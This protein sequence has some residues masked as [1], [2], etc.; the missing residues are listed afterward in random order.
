MHEA[1]TSRSPSDYVS[2][3]EI[4]QRLKI[5]TRKTAELTTA[6]FWPAAIELAPRILRWSWSEIERALAERAPRRTERREPEALRLS[7]DRRPG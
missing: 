5:G 4:A 3:K 6:D 2:K 1:A 7:R